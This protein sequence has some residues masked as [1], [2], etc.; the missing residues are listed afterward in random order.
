MRYLKFALSAWSF[1]LLLLPKVEVRAQQNFVPNPGFEELEDCDLVAG[2]ANKAT[3]WMIINYPVATPDIFHNC[4]SNSEFALPADGCTAVFPNSGDGMARLVNLGLNER[5]YARLLE[6]LPF[7][8]DIYVAYSI[9]PEEPCGGPFEFIC[10]SNTQCLAFS[11]LDLM[12]VDVVLQLDDILDETQSWTRQRTCYR[13]NGSEKMILLGN[14]RSAAETQQ[15]CEYINP[16]VNTAFFYV[17]DV[18]VAPFD[19]IPDTLYLCGDETVTVN[20]TF[21]DVPIS[22]NDGFNGAI[23][24]IENGGP[25][26]VLGDIG[27][28]FLQDETF[29]VKIP[30]ERQTINVSLC[31]ED[32]IQLEAPVPARWPN[33]EISTRFTVDRPGVY[34]ANLLSDCGEQEIEYIVE[35]GEC[36]ITHFVPNI[37]SPNRDGI[38]DRL[39][40]YFEADYEFSG[41]LSV[42]DRW[43]N[44]LFQSQSSG[45]LFTEFWDGRFRGW[46]L[47]TGVYIWS[48]R[49]T[50]VGG[51]KQHVLGGDVTLIR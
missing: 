17:D 42:F 18:V 13:A 2:E 30:D 24:T 3:P 15:A 26:T 25:Y 35:E 37:F 23:R 48:Y 47:G 9:I 32:E 12:P 45:S 16:A 14:F 31:E 50:R 7:N 5:I 8:T 1:L 36:S 49:Y 19:V 51:K 41:E 43:G 33:Q 6:D 21:F 40:F 38:N 22:W 10:Y 20:A 39:E 34:I 44:L 46:E 29:V 11:G 27:E 4:S 28:C